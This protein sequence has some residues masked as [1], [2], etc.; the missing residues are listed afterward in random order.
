MR[1]SKCG[2]CCERTEMLLS[3]EDVERLESVGF[4]QE[5][6]AVIG[7]DGLTRL[8]NVG[9]WCYFYDSEEKKCQVYEYR[10][11]GCCIYPIICSIDEG[12]ITD[13]LCPM[14]HTIS[15]HELRMRGKILVKHL[16]K[17]NH[18]QT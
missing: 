9:E 17:I 1:C 11:L 15:K 5:D 14:R 4:S 2:K 8:G 16:K 12:V 3:K 10:P 7:G 18:S 6:F 13:E